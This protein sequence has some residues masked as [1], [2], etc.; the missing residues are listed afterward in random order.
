MHKEYVMRTTIDLPDDLVTKAMNLSE[1]RTKTAVIIAA[2][3]EYIRKNK[4]QGLKRYR[5]RVNLEID[6][7]KLRKRS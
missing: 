3:E 4:I 7:D 2:L 5:G 1:H 6:L